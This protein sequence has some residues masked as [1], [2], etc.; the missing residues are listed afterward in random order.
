MNTRRQIRQLA[1]ADPRLLELGD[2]QV[3]TRRRDCNHVQRRKQQ[4]AIGDSM[5]LVALGYGNRFYARGALHFKLGDRHLRG[6]PYARFTDALRGLTVVC[7]SRE[8]HPAILTTYWD[9]DIKRRA[10]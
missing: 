10:R 3:V 1:A 2:I 6:T 5:I 8:P 4:R 9:W 7:Q